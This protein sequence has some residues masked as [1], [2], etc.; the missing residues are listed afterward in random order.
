M[1]CHRL[2]VVRRMPF[3]ALLLEHVLIVAFGTDV[4]ART[5]EHPKPRPQAFVSGGLLPAAMRGTN[6]SAPIHICDWYSTFSKMAGVDPTD[7]HDGVRVMVVVMVCVWGG[8]W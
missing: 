7:D 5:P 1:Y 2:L 6:T 4:C 8:F 3:S